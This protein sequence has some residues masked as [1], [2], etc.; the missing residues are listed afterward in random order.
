MR[1]KSIED[2]DEQLYQVVY[3]YEVG[4]DGDEVESHGNIEKRLVN[5]KTVDELVDFLIEAWEIPDGVKEG[6]RVYARSPKTGESI[7]G[8]LS[9]IRNYDDG[10]PYADIMND[11]GV[12][13]SVD[14]ENIRSI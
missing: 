1:I 11:K 13:Y 2:F 6:D 8:T 14:F 5:D 12:V 7:I 3:I 10:S 4:V 9:M